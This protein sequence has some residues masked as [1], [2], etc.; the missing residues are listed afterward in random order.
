VQL[1]LSTDNKDEAKCICVCYDNSE[2]AEIHPIL[3]NQAYKI[4]KMQPL[5]LSLS[6]L[7]G[8]KEEDK[9]AIF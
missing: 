4:K 9:I 7:F 3:I 5:E 6:I 2:N 1:S 8:F